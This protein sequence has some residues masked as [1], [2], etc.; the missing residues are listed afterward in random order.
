MVLP[1]IARLLPIGK[2]KFQRTI[3]PSFTTAFATTLA[4]AT[5]VE[6]SYGS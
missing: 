4:E 5:A 3:Q 6:K 2:T 1:I